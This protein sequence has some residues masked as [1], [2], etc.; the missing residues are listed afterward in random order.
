MAAAIQIPEEHQVDAIFILHTHY[1]AVVNRLSPMTKLHGLKSQL[2][3]L[4]FT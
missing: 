3:H 1:D 4:F 2:Y